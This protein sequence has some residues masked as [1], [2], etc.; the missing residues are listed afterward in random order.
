[1]EILATRMEHLSE[2]RCRMIGWNDRRGPGSSRRSLGMQKGNPMD[3]RNRHR[4]ARI[5]GNRNPAQSDNDFGLEEFLCSKADPRTTADRARLGISFEGMAERGI[6]HKEFGSVDPQ[7]YQD[8]IQ[9]LP[10][11]KNAIE[12]KGSGLDLFGRN[13]IGNPDG[14]RTMSKTTRNPWPS[15]TAP[16][17]PVIAGSIVRARDTATTC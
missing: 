9:E 16:G 5:L 7:S 8:I 10:S 13:S 4:L 11:R 6:S 3:L 14:I 12:G 1:M 15:R 17:L 2:D